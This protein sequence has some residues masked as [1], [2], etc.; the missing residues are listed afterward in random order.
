LL[1]Y[2]RWHTDPDDPRSATTS[3]EFVVLPLDHPQSKALA[4]LQGPESGPAAWSPDSRRVAVGDPWSS[5][6]L[7]I[8]AVRGGTKTEVIDVVPADLAWTRRGIYT[9]T[10][11]QAGSHETSFSSIQTPPTGDERWADKQA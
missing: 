10:G 4:T 7:E 9:F 6:S 5:N 8:V 11:D 1:L 3:V 2:E